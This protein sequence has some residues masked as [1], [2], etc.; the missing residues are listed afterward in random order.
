MHTLQWV[1]QV[2][3]EVSNEKRESSYTVS[4]KQSKDV[5]RDYLFIQ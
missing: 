5:L 2:F 3:I 4:Y 1:K